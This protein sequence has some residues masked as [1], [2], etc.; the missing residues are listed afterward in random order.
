MSAAHTGPDRPPGASVP[1]MGLLFSAICRGFSPTA[2]HLPELPSCSVWLK[3][4]GQAAAS[5]E[6]AP[7]FTCFACRQFPPVSPQ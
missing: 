1:R 6:A 2:S 7:S 4:S 5:P 3:G